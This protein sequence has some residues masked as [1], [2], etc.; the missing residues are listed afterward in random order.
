MQLCSV[1]RQKGCLFLHGEGVRK[2]VHT[3][4][5]PF[6]HY[7]S[8]RKNIIIIM[9]IILSFINSSLLIYFYI[10]KDR[11]ALEILPLCPICLC[12]GPA[13][14]PYPVVGFFLCCVLLLCVSSVISLFDCQVFSNVTVSLQALFLHVMWLWP[15]P[16]CTFLLQQI[17]HAP[18]PNR[19]CLDLF[20]NKMVNMVQSTQYTVRLLSQSALFGKS[21]LSNHQMQETC[22]WSNWIRR[23]LMVLASE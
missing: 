11:K 12:F 5:H 19:I 8:E 6:L 16:V 15:S 10:L 7:I 23:L 22:N 21:L 3:C 17:N 20:L 4:G 14:T 13:F 18:F 9:T 2:N 1:F